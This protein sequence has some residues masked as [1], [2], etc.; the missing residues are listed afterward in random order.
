MGVK[1]KSQS[2]G[3]MCFKCGELGH[4]SYD[5]KKTIQNHKATLFVE[6]SIGKTCEELYEESSSDIVE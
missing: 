5:C 3:F 1:N 4:K 2:I 6:E